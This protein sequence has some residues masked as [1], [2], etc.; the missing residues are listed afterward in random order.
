M[1]LNQTWWVTWQIC[2]KIGV[3]EWIVEK[4]DPEALGPYAYKDGEWVGYDDEEMAAKKVTLTHR[5]ITA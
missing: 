3:D 5:P 2:E 1:L 4:P